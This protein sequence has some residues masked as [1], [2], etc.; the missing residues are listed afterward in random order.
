MVRTI[1]AIL[2]ALTGYL[3]YRLWVGAGSLAETDQLQAR[4]E[5]KQAANEILDHRN[6]VLR[7]EIV[8]LRNGLD[9]IEEKARSELGMIKKGETFFLLVDGR[10]SSSD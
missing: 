10:D 9:A 7:A 8:E 3:Q 6:S 2:L 5:R 1:I 4:V